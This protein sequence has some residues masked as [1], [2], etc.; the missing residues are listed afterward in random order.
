MLISLI[1]RCTI[2]RSKTKQGMYI[3]VT[4][5]TS[6]Q[7][8]STA[9][10]PTLPQTKPCTNHCAH[11]VT[12]PVHL[13]NSKTIQPTC[14]STLGFQV[15]PQS[16]AAR[17]RV[18]FLNQLSTARLGFG[19]TTVLQCHWRTFNYYPLASAVLQFQP[20]QWQGFTLY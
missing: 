13:G 3:E 18:C 15:Q 14:P 9:V 17:A 11:C 1:G 8:I 20:A 7:P 16:I 19:L 10:F 2:P 5:P 6:R 12:L 4:A